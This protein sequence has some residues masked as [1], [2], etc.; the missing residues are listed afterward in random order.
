MGFCNHF[1]TQRSPTIWA[2]G[3]GFVEDSLSKDGVGVMVQ[4]VMPTMGAADKA[5]LASPGLISCCVARFLT[6]QGLLLVHNPGLKIPVQI[7]LPFVKWHI[8]PLHLCCAQSLSRVRLFETSGT[9]A[10]QDPLSIAFSRQECWHGLPFPI[11]GIFLTQQ[12]N[13]HL[14]HLLH[15]Q[16][17][18]LP[19]RPL[20]SPYYVSLF[21]C[22]SS[23]KP[24]CLPTAQR[25][26]SKQSDGYIR[27]SPTLPG[28]N[29]C[30]LSFH[31][32][33]LRLMHLTIPDQFM[34]FHTST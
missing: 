14:L 20:G 12:S 17:D 2:A 34:A 7:S 28:P 27:R 31:S 26:K 32:W 10:S 22:L 1:L 19:L 30:L 13:L 11:P 29:F 24:S 6:D 23:L 9:V 18:S 25:V 4:T 5:S 3:I 33:S 16:E 21:N 8:F 15:W